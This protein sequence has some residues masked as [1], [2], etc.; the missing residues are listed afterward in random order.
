MEVRWALDAW[1]AVAFLQGEA[2]ASRVRQA[3]AEGA[4]INDVS[5]GEVLYT[6]VRNRGSDAALDA[7]RDLRGAL[8]AEAPDWELT[9]A[10]ALV[11]AGGGLSYADSFAVATAKRRGAPLLTGDPEIVELAADGVEVIDLREGG[12]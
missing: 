1:A 8:V 10:A 7:V 3:L 9:R 11:K 6:L 5:L 12:S 2:P 4:V